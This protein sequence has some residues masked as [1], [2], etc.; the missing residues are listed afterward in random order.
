MD[1]CNDSC[2][3][4][5]L[6]DFGQYGWKAGHMESRSWL[7]YYSDILYQARKTGTSSP[8]GMLFDHGI[9]AINSSLL[10]LPLASALGVGS[11]MSIWW[12]YLTGWPAFYMQTLEEYYREAMVLP[13]ING[14]TEGILFTCALCLYSSFYGPEHLHE[15]TCQF[16][17]IQ[18]LPLHV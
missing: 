10:M 5:H 11:S 16:H 15:V 2:Q 6:P 14:P 12:F 3:F 17:Y 8:L 9:D 1:C 4:V 18:F 13:F 7:V